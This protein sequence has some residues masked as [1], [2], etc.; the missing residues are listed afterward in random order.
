MTANFNPDVFFHRFKNT[1]FNWLSF[2]YIT[3]QTSTS[4]LHLCSAITAHQRI[5]LSFGSKRLQ[6]CQL[7]DEEPLWDKYISCILTAWLEGYW[8]NNWLHQNH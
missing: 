1:A 5:W 8:S 4:H 2:I 3:S 7:I 6:P